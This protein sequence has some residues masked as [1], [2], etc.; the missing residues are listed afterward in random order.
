MLPTLLRWRTDHDHVV[1]AEHDGTDL[2]DVHRVTDLLGLTHVEVNVLVEP[3]ENTS[4]GPAASH[5]YQHSLAD[6]SLQHLFNH[7]RQLIFLSGDT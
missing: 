6:A 7:F 2:L 1:A 5:L 4:Q 3:L